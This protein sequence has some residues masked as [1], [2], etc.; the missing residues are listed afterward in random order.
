MGAATVERYFQRQIE[1]K[2]RERNAEPCPRVLGIDEHFFT[3]RKGFA[4]TFC[5][6]SKHKIHDLALGRSQLSLEPYI[7]RRWMARTRSV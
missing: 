4:T 1:R 2:L 5:D 6:L 3:R 7:C